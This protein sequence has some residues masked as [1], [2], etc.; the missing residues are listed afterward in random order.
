MKPY[1][2]S[3][4]KRSRMKIVTL[5]L[6]LSWVPINA[7]ACSCAEWSLPEAYEYFEFIFIGTIVKHD[8]ADWINEKL[9][10]F[11][12]EVSQSYKSDLDNK[13]VIYSHP[14]SATCGFKFNHG[15]EYLVFANIP[16][17]VDESYQKEGFPNVSL[18]SPTTH[19][20]P[21]RSEMKRRRV[22]QYLETLDPDT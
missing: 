2:E 13:I 5:F 4:A 15:K 18:C 7:L 19:T 8:H 9:D 11:E 14:A 21:T 17:R 16:Y 3:R 12:F 20:T 6:I 10:R 1:Y 22:M